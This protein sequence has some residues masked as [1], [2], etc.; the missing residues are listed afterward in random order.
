MQLFS[1]IAVSPAQTGHVLF[2]G[3]RRKKANGKGVAGATPM[4]YTQVTYACQ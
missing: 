2:P 4:N 1:S 3:F